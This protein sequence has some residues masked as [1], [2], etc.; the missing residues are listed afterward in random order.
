[1]DVAYVLVTAVLLFLSLFALLWNAKSET[2]FGTLPSAVASSEVEEGGGVTL[3]A[4]GG[5]MH[6]VTF[7][8]AS[9]VFAGYGMLLSVWLCC[10]C[11]FVVVLCSLYCS[12]RGLR[13]LTH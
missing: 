11:T 6:E 8:F 7:A 13:P 3:G 9:L 4:G 1:M 12:V 5:R 2:G 10:V